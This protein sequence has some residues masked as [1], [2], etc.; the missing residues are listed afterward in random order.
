MR[1]NNPW[2]VAVDVCRALEVQNVTQALDRLDNDERAMFNIGRQGE[3]N[4][5]NEPGLYSL[6][7][8]SLRTSENFWIS[9]PDNS[10]TIKQTRCKGLVEPQNRS[11]PNALYMA[12]QR[13][14]QRQGYF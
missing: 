9:F 5:I 14:M 4:I 10:I 6:V 1:D 2:F 7:L 13:Y 12:F 3:T 11:F 8:G